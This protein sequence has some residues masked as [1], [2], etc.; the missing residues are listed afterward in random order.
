MTSKSKTD[1]TRITQLIAELQAIDTALHGLNK[2]WSPSNAPSAK[3]V[4]HY[5]DN[6]NSGCD[7]AVSLDVDTA[8]DILGVQRAAKLIALRLHG[9]DVE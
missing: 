1:L 9:L 6:T 7:Q 2:P 4:V 8:R 5:V 3:I